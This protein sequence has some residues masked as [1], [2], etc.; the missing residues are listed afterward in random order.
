MIDNSLL[1]C[2]NCGTKMHMGYACGEHFVFP[3]GV[4][5]D[6]C[7][8]FVEMHASMQQER[9]VWNKACR[10]GAYIVGNGHMPQIG[11]IERKAMKR[12]AE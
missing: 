8:G 4:G 9:N 10:R 1:P 7:Q 2:A 6:W 12:G 5:C 3:D 11:G